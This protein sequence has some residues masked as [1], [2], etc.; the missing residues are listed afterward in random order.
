MT[1]KNSHHNLVDVLNTKQLKSINM[2]METLNQRQ[3]LITCM[4]RKKCNQLINM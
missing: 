3:Q 2:N 1:S 4:N